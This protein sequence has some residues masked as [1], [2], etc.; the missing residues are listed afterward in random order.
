M[1]KILSLF[2][3]VSIFS[4]VG[5]AQTPPTYNVA[6]FQACIY[7][8]PS[9]DPDSLYNSSTGLNMNTAAKD[10]APKIVFRSIL[11][12]GGAGGQTNV[13]VK[14]ETQNGAFIT[15]PISSVAAYD[16]WACPLPGQFL[17]VVKTGTTA[18]YV[19]PLF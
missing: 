10:F 2:F 15:L 14:L 17:K 6:G 16:M 19:F 11:V 8:D 9:L 12:M 1:E 5:F 7:E 18:T 3:L 13:T 4:F